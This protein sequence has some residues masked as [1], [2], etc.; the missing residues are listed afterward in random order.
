M[1]TTSGKRQKPSKIELDRR[2]R[3]YL[4]GGKMV[5]PIDMN[6]RIELIRKKKR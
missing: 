3:Y 2:V 5:D 6:K 4:N 1:Q